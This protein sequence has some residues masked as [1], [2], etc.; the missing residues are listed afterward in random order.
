MSL[1]Q[2]KQ[3]IEEAIASDA[4]QD[5]AYEAQIVGLQSQASAAI[6]QRDVYLSERSTIIADLTVVR[7]QLQAQ[8]VSLDARIAALQSGQ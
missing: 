8:V 4:A 1:E 2:A 6:A 7:D 5:A 3:L